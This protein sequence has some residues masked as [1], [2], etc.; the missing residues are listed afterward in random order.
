MKLRTRLYLIGVLSLGYVTVAIG[1]VKATFLLQARRNPDSQF[2]QDIQFWGFLQLNM[3][4][5]VACAPTLRPL[6]GRALKLS[7]RDKYYGNYY[8]NQRS[9]SHAQRL[10]NRRT[11]MFA[12]DEV[13]LEDMEAYGNKTTNIKTTIR[14]EVYDKGGERSG[15]EELILQ[16]NVVEPNGILRTTEIDVRKD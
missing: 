5:I 11:A 13:A 1:A 14:A 3:G 8:G 2:T 7:S 9:E 6:V 15:S 16:G 10:A 4:I 12:A